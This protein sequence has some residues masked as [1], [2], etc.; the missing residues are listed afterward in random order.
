MKTINMTPSWVA[1][2]RIYV[3]VL[4]NP[5][6]TLGAHDDAEQDLLRLARSMDERIAADALDHL[7]AELSAKTCSDGNGDNCP[8]CWQCEDDSNLPGLMRRQAE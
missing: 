6:A 3:A 4:R 5:N 8:G 2:V 1:A 7:G